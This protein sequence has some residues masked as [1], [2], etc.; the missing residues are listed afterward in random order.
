[1]EYQRIISASKILKEAGVR[2]ISM[3][4]NVFL[5]TAKKAHE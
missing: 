1:M 4:S 3:V 5:M 2:Y